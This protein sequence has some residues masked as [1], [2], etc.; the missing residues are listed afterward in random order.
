MHQKVAK[1]PYCSFL[2]S[3]SNNYNAL[4]SSSGG[5]CRSNGGGNSSG[6][7]SSGDSSSAVVVV[8]VGRGVVYA[9]AHCRC[10]PKE[11]QPTPQDSPL[12][13]QLAEEFTGDLEMVYICILGFI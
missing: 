5:C 11:N 8:V 12:V 6:D 10:L 9:G 13:Q 7:I 3:A 4:I 2:S 1:V